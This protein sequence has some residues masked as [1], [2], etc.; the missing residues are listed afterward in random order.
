VMKN[1]KKRVSS[2][3]DRFPKSLFA[4]SRCRIT[5]DDGFK[6]LLSRLW[7][8]VDERYEV[9]LVVQQ[10][11][12][13]KSRCVGGSWL[14]IVT[15]SMAGARIYREDMTRVTASHNRLGLSLSK[16]I[17]HKL[18]AK[19]NG[20]SKPRAYEALGQILMGHS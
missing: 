18:I 14:F 3:E 16:C 5:E 7:L 15:S 8:H 11:R 17:R 9:A 13:Q 12:R 10:R 4:L 1:F 2:H 20:K 6:D 19:I